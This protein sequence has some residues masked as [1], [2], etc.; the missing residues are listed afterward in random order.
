MEGKRKEGRRMEGKRAGRE[1]GE[2]YI[3]RTKGRRNGGG[4]AEK[5]HSGGIL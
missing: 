2:G 4:M 1:V 5:N 3:N